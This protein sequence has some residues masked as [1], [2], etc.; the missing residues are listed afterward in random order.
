M[1]FVRG[2]APSLAPGLVVWLAK[3]RVYALPRYTECKAA[4]RDDTTF[5]SGHGVALNA[6]TSRLS[7]GTTL[8]SDGEDHD[9]LGWG[10]LDGSVD[11]T[12]TRP[13]LSTWPG[14]C[15]WSCRESNPL[16]K[17]S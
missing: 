13:G 14:L 3:Q 10:N 15:R 4:L 17:S 5:A 11:K 6:L 2:R 8:N 9:R 7:R 1:N 16:L 12:Q